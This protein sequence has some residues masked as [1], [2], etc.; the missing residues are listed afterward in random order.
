[1]FLFIKTVAIRRLTMGSRA[2]HLVQHSL[3]PPQYHAMKA[4]LSMVQS[5]S[6]AMMPAGMTQQAAQFK[7]NNA[8]N[9]QSMTL[10]KR[11]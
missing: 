6:S 4:T 1:M 8:V 10:I 3:K 9:V 7:V 5:P 2:Y 11:F